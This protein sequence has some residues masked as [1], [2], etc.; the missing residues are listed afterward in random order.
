MLK[1][2]LRVFKSTFKTLNLNNESKLYIQF[3]EVFQRNYQILGA[4]N[5]LASFAML[6]SLEWKYL[7]C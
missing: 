6:M 5:L 4:W 2:E 1:N 7:L 3:T